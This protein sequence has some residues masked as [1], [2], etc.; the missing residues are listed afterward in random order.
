MSEFD[1]I[2]SA[3]LS[4]TKKV[5]TNIKKLIGVKNWKHIKT[6][7]DFEGVGDYNFS[8]RLRL[9]WTGLKKAAVSIKGVVVDIGS[10]IL[11]R[12]IPPWFWWAVVG[13]LVLAVVLIIIL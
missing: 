7:K 6:K 10:Q 13:V 4:K 2:K 12:T 3:P 1:N 8:N 9:I 11:K 5:F